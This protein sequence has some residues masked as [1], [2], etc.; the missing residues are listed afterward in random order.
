MEHAKAI[1]RYTCRCGWTIVTKN[2]VEGVTPMFVTCESCGRD[3]ASHMYR[4]RQNL[5]PTHEWYR[6]TESELA[7]EIEKSKA[8][9]LEKMEA[10]GEEPPDDIDDL[11]RADFLRHIES[12]GLLMREASA[13]GAAACE[14]S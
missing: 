5:V 2:V 4:V 13:E 12:G 11:L 10:R 3:A 8:R 9:I 7:D 6:P 1:N 14:S